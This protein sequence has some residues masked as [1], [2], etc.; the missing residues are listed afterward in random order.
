[1]TSRYAQLKA[2]GELRKIRAARNLTPEE[3]EEREKIE[4]QNRQDKKNANAQAQ[5]RLINAHS[6]AHR[7]LLEDERAYL[8]I[9]PSFPKRSNEIR[10][11]SEAQRRAAVVLR[12][13]HSF[14]Y[15][16]YYSQELLAIKNGFRNHKNA[17]STQR[18]SRFATKATF[19][20]SAACLITAIAFSIVSL[21][22]DGEDAG[23]ASGYPDSDF[24]TYQGPFHP[25]EIVIGRRISVS[26][27]ATGKSG[28]TYDDEG[29]IIA[30]ASGM[31]PVRND[32]GGE[33]KPVPSDP[34]KRC[35]GF[36]TTFAAYGLFPIET[37][38]YLAWRE[39]RCNPLSQNAEWD[40]NGNMTYHLNKNK[41]YDTGL[42][43]INSSWRS[44]VRD[45]CGPEA[46]ENYMSGLK[47]VDCNLRVVRYIMEN[48]AGGLANWRM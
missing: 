36:E 1:M 26:E 46:L 13:D 29:T 19:S 20:A 5:I 22:D 8:R 42:L 27:V 9:D 25:E 2:S 37:W 32:H 39:S 24:T 11:E 12:Y 6:S 17:Q 21:G 7:R 10:F 35:P 38:S 41:T 45:I 31:E 30:M 48:S 4:K 3:R 44:V 34:T 28:I 18:R 47:D 43:Q 33:R 23:F 40:E 16:K 15:E 14:E